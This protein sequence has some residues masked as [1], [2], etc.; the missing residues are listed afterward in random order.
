CY[1]KYGNTKTSEI[2]D[3]IKKL[4][5]GFATKAGI[6]VSI[7]EIIVPKEKEQILGNAEEK[8]DEIDRKFRRGLITEKERYDRVIDIWSKTKDEL[9]TTLM[10]G[11]DKFNPIYMMANS[12]ARGNESQIT[13]LAGM[14]GLMADPTGRII[15]LPIKAN[16]R[17]GLTVLEY[18]ISTHGARKGLADTALKTADS[19]YLTRRLVDV[20]QDVIIREYDCGATNGVSLTEY[21]ETGND[22]LEAM[23]RVIGRFSLED[24]YHPETG[25]VLIPA[26]TMIDEEM[27]A[28]L[29]ALGINE[30]RFRSVLTCK[31]KH[32]VCVKCYGRNLATGK[33]VDVGEAVGIIAAQSIGEPGTQLTM[34]TFHTG[35][36]AGDDI[37]QGL[38]RVEELF[39]A[40]KP[41]GQ[42][43]ISEISGTVEIFETRYEKELK[44]TAEHG[45]VRKYKIPYGSRLKVTEGQVINAGDE[46]TKGSINPH[47]L[48]KVKGVRG[49]QIYML[50]EVQNVYHMQ[51]VDINDKHIEVIVRQ[52]LKK[53]KVEDPGDTDLLP[54]GIID[55]FVFEEVNEEVITEGGKPALARPLLSG[56][57]KASLATD[58]FLSAASF[59][60]TTRVL[61]DAAIRGRVDPLLGLKENVIIG[62]LVP[63]GTGMSRY[64]NIRVFPTEADVLPEKDEV[65]GLPEG[66]ESVADAGEKEAIPATPGEN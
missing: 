41:K 53:V 28:E 56:I 42:S 55:S 23:D 11:L 36:V 13:Q 49:V 35:G 33:V 27:A 45:E 20:A 63:A 39:E 40:R 15:D 38:P 64:R 34:R 32:C 48:L 65:M 25:E 6:T 19:G 62:K 4:G 1:R 29:K 14:R 46:L 18:F 8:V 9:T 44:I 61:T 12:G 37:T 5:F 10:E 52:M 54:G 3:D 26:D 21:V 24:I 58:S 16:F 43:V 66:A 31:T 17:E 22:P 57:T 60:E 59:Q 50:Q 47:E 2:L 51:G 7:E 30:I